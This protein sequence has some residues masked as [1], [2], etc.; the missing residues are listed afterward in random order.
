MLLGQPAADRTPT[1]FDYDASTP[2]DVIGAG[3]SRHGAAAVQDVSYASP[4]G[5]R[6]PA[7]LVVPDGRGPF[8]GIVFVHWGQGNRSEFVAEALAVADA[9]AISLLLD[10]P[11]NRV[12]K[13]RRHGGTPDDPEYE[14][15]DYV[16]LVTDIRRGVDLLLA[17]ADVDAKRIG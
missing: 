6:V 5:G 16:Q 17:R 1:V 12:K 10:A 11:F 4:K 9:G 13:D 8:A 3:A 2:I 7:Y 14:R 15:D